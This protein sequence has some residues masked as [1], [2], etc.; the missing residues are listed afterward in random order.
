[1]FKPYKTSRQQ[2]QATR[3]C[4][5]M[6]KALRDANTDDA[7]DLFVEMMQHVLLV[8]RGNYKDMCKGK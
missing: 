1:M 5:L 6:T 8:P 4:R 2:K 7:H 3:A